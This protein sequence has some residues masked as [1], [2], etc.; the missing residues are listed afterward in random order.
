MLENK[1]KRKSIRLKSYDYSEPSD[2]F[3]TICAEDRKCLFGEI[4]DGEMV[5]NSLGEIVKEEILNILR[6]F[7]NVEIDIFCIMP[8][9]I[10]IIL[11]IL[12]G[13]DCPIVGATLAVARNQDRAGA[14]P[15]PTVGDIIGSFKSICFKR[16]KNYILKNGLNVKTKFWQRNY[17][18]HVI[19]NEKSYD[20][21]YTYIES[22]ASLWEKDRNNPKNLV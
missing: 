21:I 11:S 3:V 22:N 18:E 2:Y 9:H 20:E 15:A 5:L 6:R 8:N 10:H 17:Y 4:V 19:R 1:N 16:Y 13:E 7:I 14:S 12:C